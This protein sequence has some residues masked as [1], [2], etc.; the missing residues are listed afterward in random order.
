MGVVFFV[1]FYLFIYFL[2]IFYFGGVDTVQYQCLGYTHSQGSLGLE[3]EL[4]V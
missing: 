4:A 1:G 3:L 2:F